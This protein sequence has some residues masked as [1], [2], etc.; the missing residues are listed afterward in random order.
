MLAKNRPQVVPVSILP[1]SILSTDANISFQNIDISAIDESTNEATSIPKIDI[2]LDEEM[3][4]LQT[5]QVKDGDNIEGGKLKGD[6][7]EYLQIM[8]NKH[9]ERG[10][11]IADNEQTIV[12]DSF[13]GAEHL[14]SKK[15]V[16]SLISFSSTM[17]TP[18]QMNKKQVTVGSSLNILTWQQIRGVENLSVMLPSVNDHYRKKGELYTDT[19]MKYTLLYDM[20]DGKML[21]LLTHHSL[22]NRK[23]HPFLLCQC[24]RGAGVRDKNHKCILL[25]H[26]EQVHFYARSLRR[27]NM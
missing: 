14:K 1:S 15:K 4:F 5:A 26:T 8:R 7:G 27:W 6:Y 25:T 3:E 21:Y 11:K 20:H 13:D 17:F 16:T 9:A 12:I 24:E 22:W 10:T 2:D 18:N 23:K 19:Q